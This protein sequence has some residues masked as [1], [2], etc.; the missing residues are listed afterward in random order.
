MVRD[1]KLPKRIRLV[2]IMALFGILTGLVLGSG[3]GKNG[4]PVLGQKAG[5][6]ARLI[7]VQQLPEV[8]GPMC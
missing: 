1:A 3:T 5:G 8:D 7:S 6:D 2:G 4:G